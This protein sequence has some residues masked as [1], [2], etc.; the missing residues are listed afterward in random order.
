MEAKVLKHGEPLAP[1]F[2][3]GTVLWR[4]VAHFGSSEV[5]I[6]DMA[7]E[8]TER[9]TYIARVVL[10]GGSGD[11]IDE[12]VVIPNRVDD[13][14]LFGLVLFVDILPEPEWTHLLVK[15]VSHAMTLPYDKEE[16]VRRLKGGAIFATTTKPY[17]MD[18][19]LK[20]RSTIRQQGNLN[21]TFEEKLKVATEVQPP[22]YRS[23]QLRLVTSWRYREEEALMDYCHIRHSKV[24]DE[25]KTSST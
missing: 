11:F 23:Q 4:S 13:Q 18:D 14:P 17:N 6:N 20:F 3:V 8:K 19:Y 7:W 12:P 5:R 10:A 2:R 9:G 24:L 16:G 21:S 22:E 1:L 15:R 25:T